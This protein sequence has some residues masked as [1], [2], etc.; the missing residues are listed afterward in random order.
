M[1]AYYCF[2]SVFCTNLISPGAVKI[3]YPF[4]E[5]T[6]HFCSGSNYEKLKVF[7]KQ[8]LIIEGDCFHL[9][10][11]VAWKVFLEDCCISI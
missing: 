10:N 3:H 5:K 9:G 4:T 1:A 6:L 8:M 2:Q 11:K 7:Y